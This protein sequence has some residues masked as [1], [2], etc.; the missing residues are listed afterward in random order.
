MLKN[1]ESAL[2]FLATVAALALPAVPALQEL[3]ASHIGAVQSATAPSIPP[4][5]DSL[6]AVS[7]PRQVALVR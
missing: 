3:R 2:F 5:A 6:R 7:S 4:V 1:A